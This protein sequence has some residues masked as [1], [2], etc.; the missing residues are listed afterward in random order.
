MR[1]N[2]LGPKDTFTIIGLS[3]SSL[4]SYVCTVNIILA[5]LEIGGVIRLTVPPTVNTDACNPRIR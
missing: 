2:G 1:L 4:R 3:V 5:Q